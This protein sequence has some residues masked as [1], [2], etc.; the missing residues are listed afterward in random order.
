LAFSRQLAAIQPETS[1]K[2][3]SY[4]NNNNELRPSMAAARRQLKLAAFVLD[5]MPAPAACGAGNNWLRSGR[6]LRLKELG[7]GPFSE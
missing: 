1:G 5:V 3:K 4:N 2:S 7:D 6:K